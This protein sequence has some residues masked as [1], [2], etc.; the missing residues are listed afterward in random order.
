M[1]TAFGPPTA[2]LESIT[3]GLLEHGVAGEHLPRLAA[4]GAAVLAAA[5]DVNLT[6]ARE[7]IA[8]AAHIAD[9][10]TLTSLIT[11][12][13]IDVGSGAGLPGIPLAIVTGASVTLLDA[14]AKKVRVLARIREELAL[15]GAALAARAEDAAR[16]ERLRERFRHATARAVA[17]APA[18]AELTV[19]FL[20]IG[21]TALLQRG[22]WQAGERDALHDAALVLGAEVIE[23]R[24][25]EGE[26]RII[27]LVK[28]RATPWRF[29]R[30]DG[31]P[32]K[33]PLCMP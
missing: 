23:E 28:R 5:R 33:R 29:P 19:P 22:A 3:S 25:V 27:V 20:E 1:S 17:I 14:T 4:Y 7:P 26:R 9:A 16:D 12:P 15:P 31:V 13:F 8:F 24:V 6:A 18:V 11:G 2:V 21:G 10:L 32:V 30:R